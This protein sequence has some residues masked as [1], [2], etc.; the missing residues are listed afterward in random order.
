MAQLTF[1]PNSPTAWTVT[2]KEGENTIGR[3][4]DNDVCTSEGGVS[5]HHCRVS[6]NQGVVTITDLNSTNGTS[7]NGNPITQ[8]V[9]SP[10]QIIHLGQLPVRL[11]GAGAI[12]VATLVATPT[13]A[14]GAPAVKSA[15][16]LRIHT[17]A[18]APEPAAAVETPAAAVEPPPAL[19]TAAFMSAPAGTRCRSHSKSPARWHC[20]Q[21]QKFFCDLCVAT[22][23]STHGPSHMCRGCGVECQPVRTGRMVEA[24][25]RG[26]FARLPGAFVYPFRGTGSLILI[27]AALV[28]A[29]LAAVS[30]LFSILFTMMAVG[31]LFLFLQNIIHCTAA[32]DDE[33]PSLP[34]FD[35][36]FSACFTLIGT[37]AISFALPI[38]L[39]ILKLSGV[40]LPVSALIASIFIS[41]LYFPMA[42][43]AV[44]MLDSIAAANPLVVVTSIIKVPLQ[45]LV[46]VIM[47]SAVFGMRLIGDMVSS[48]AGSETYTTRDMSVMF[49]GMGIQAVWSFV[50]VYLLTV[51]MRILGILYLTQKDKL[52]WL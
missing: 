2:L 23:A 44:A 15:I 7:V 33:M 50:G 42:F 34:D 43:L 38:V 24:G 17:S 51:G 36:L 40:E 19:A 30:G 9:W 5:G 48:A 13:A 11:E 1:N 16:R 21:C 27:V 12:P 20:P 10:G 14:P 32:G 28:F 3:A 41:L 31:Y 52:G 22:R 18:P 35:G 26:F 4:D 47:L 6:L 37:M 39:G 8:A 46:A 45:Y 25:E 49:I 29:A